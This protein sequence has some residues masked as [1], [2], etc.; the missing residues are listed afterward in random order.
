MGRSIHHETIGTRRSLWQRIKELALTDVGVVARGGIAPG[1]LEALETLL[2]EA[3]FG[4]QTTTRLVDGVE[5][6]ARA[7]AVRSSEEFLGALRDGV[8]A[9]LRAG[10]SDASLE[11]AAIPP[12]VMLVIGVN[13]AGKTTVVGKLAERLRHQGK[14]VL[15]AAA[16]TFRAGAVDQLRIWAQRAGARFVGGAAGRDPAAVAVDAIEAGVAGH[17]DVI[18]IDTAG[19]LHTSAALMDELAKVARVVAKRVPGAPHETLLVLD[20]TI[21]QNALAQ[22]KMFTAA[23]PVT[24]L[25][26]T[27]VDGTAKGGVVVAVHEALNVPIKFIGVGEELDDLVPFDAASFARRVLET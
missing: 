17:V 26:V 13:G 4:V 11:L 12:T 15:V 14:Q 1:S 3:D 6:S 16:D 20:A 25:I 22:G 18:L 9:A 8:E 2:L 19:R 23:V 10:N 5:R 7:G 27:K 21:G 24:G